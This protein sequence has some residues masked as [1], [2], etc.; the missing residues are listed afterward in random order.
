M[1]T[2]LLDLSPLA[3]TSS[4]HDRLTPHIEHLEKVPLTSLQDSEE[5][6][7]LAIEPV[8]LRR[9]VVVPVDPFELPLWLAPWH[10]GRSRR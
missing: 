7:C 10:L 5:S 9:L 1:H 8:A 6:A 3:L 2:D 4:I